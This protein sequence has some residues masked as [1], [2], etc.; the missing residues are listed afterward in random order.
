MKFD[1]RY[2]LVAILF[3]LF[4][5]E[6]AF[7][8][9]FAVA[10]DDGLRLTD[11]YVVAGVSDHISPWQACYR[12]TQLF[13]AK[14]VEFVLSQAGHMQAILNPPGNPKARYY[15]SKKPGHPPAD[16]DDWLKGTEEV[17]GSWWPYWMDWL[18]QRSGKKIAAPKSVAWP[19]LRSM[20]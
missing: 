3:I 11:A 16:V 8:F 18:Q 5:L 10:L 14:N 20:A 1:V 4:D 9:P 13:G 15:V 7:L 2:Y 12:S 6:I 19:E 17:A